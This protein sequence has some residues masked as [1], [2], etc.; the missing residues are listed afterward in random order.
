MKSLCN[1][2][3]S[4]CSLPYMIYFTEFDQGINNFYMSLCFDRGPVGLAGLSPPLGTLKD[5]GP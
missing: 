2:P 4:T 3:V 5:S 1:F